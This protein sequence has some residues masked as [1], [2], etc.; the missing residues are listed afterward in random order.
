MDEVHFFWLVC[1]QNLLEMN[2]LE[3][4]YNSIRS[5]GLHPCRKFIRKR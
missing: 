3:V 1:L 4:S 5:E 2:P